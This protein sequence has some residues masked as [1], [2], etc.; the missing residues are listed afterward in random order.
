MT[1]HF[2]KNFLVALLRLSSFCR[3]AAAEGCGKEL[4]EDILE[5]Q[6]TAPAELEG[7]RNGYGVAVID[8]RE[9]VG[10]ERIFNMTA[11]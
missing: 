3:V 2:I 10:I 1:A 4:F 11:T 7:K 6:I 8:L 9:G 5:V